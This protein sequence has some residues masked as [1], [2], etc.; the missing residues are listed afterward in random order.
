MGA[1]ISM[2]ILC[3]LLRTGYNVYRNCG[4]LG[5]LFVSAL[6][7]FVV[8]FLTQLKLFASDSACWS[9]SMSLGKQIIFVAAMAPRPWLPL[10]GHWGEL[11][12]SP[13]VFFCPMDS[14]AL[15]PS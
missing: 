3:F 9:T 15:V 2:H 6:Y 8:M 13:S 4:A 14:A 10:G 5:K 7:M 11:S 12:P 1:V